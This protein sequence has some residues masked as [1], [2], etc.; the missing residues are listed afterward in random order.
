MLYSNGQLFLNVTKTP[1]GSKGLI[2]ITINSRP[3]PA[4]QLQK[5]YH[6][7]YD[8]LPRGKRRIPGISN[9]V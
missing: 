7:T 2:I 8:I 4:T 3:Y 5:K 6:L 1:F 9:P